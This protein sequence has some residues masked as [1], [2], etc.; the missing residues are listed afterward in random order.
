VA[1]DRHR[2]G[3]PRVSG[4]AWRPQRRWH[5]PESL[6]LPLARSLADLVC[7]ED[8]TYVKAC[9]G[10]PCALL[11]VDRTR[12][13]CAKVVQHGG[14]RQSSKAVRT[15]A[16][17]SGNTKTFKVDIIVSRS[18]LTVEIALSQLCRG[19]GKIPAPENP[20]ECRGHDRLLC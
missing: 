10:R 18:P 8:F 2:L 17:C 4:L 6:L 12:G 7:A 20:R 1:Q 11:F 5:S 15:P 9:E 13:P 3:E 16:A 19:S 14:L